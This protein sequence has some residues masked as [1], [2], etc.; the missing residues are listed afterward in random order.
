[1]V[2]D[3]TPTTTT[4]GEEDPEAAA[5]DTAPGV[6]ILDPGPLSARMGASLVE[7]DD[8][9]IL[10]WGGTSTSEFGLESDVRMHDGATY[11]PATDEWTMI[12][13]APVP[14]TAGALLADGEVLALG[15]DAIVGWNARL[16]SWRIVEDDLPGQPESAVWT[17]D[18]LIV[19]T[20]P[21]ASDALSWIAVDPASGAV[22]AM[23]APPVE[24][25]GTPMWT[26]TDVLILGKPYG[27]G[28]PARIEG[29]A[30]SPSDGEWRRLASTSDFVQAIDTAWTGTTALVV[31]STHEAYSYDPETDSWSEMPAIPGTSGEWIPQIISD[32]DRTVVLSSGVHVLDEDRGWIPL[33]YSAVTS[34][35]ND[36]PTISPDGSLWRFGRDE[37]EGEPLT[38][39]FEVTDLEQLL[40]SGSVYLGVRIDLP[41]HAT[42]ISTDVSNPGSPAPVTTARISLG[43][44]ECTIEVRDGV[45]LLEGGSS[46]LVTIDPAHGERPWEAWV[47]GRDSLGSGSHRVDCG[48]L[49]RS[50]ELARYFRPNERWYTD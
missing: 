20:R 36:L 8:G 30:F 25:A 48:T 7:L 27:V 45:S 22:V 35:A 17:G 38:N 37:W 3:P 42:L 5:P 28:H 14:D 46:E 29:V 50:I 44:E 39:G 10:V 13:S 43:P 26:G 34:I 33:P 19:A 18:Q 1:M 32:G 15:P 4:V 47:I 12:T 21:F 23:P 11:D 9:R 31:D 16:D 41:D 6:E 40:A 49:E 24:I 2:T